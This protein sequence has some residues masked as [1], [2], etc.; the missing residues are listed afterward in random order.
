MVE[1][2]ERVR[3][4]EFLAQFLARHQFAGTKDERLQNFKGLVLQTDLP[5]SFAE[6]VVAQVN[7]EDPKMNDLGR[8]GLAPT[9]CPQERKSITL[10]SMNSEQFPPESGR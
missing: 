4:P 5:T 10:P 3:W 2:N 9:N 8:R 6:L 1:I 7:L